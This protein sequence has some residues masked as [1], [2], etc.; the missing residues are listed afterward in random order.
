MG[1]AEIPGVLAHGFPGEWMVGGC[2]LKAVAA[3][4]VAE[5]PGSSPADSLH[6]LKRERLATRSLGI[7]RE[8]RRTTTA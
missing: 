1:V 4:G 3:V 5:I 2:R 6:F 8:R 7:A